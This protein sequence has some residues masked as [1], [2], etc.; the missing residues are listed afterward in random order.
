VAALSYLLFSLQLLF[1]LPASP[2]AATPLK[3]NPL[4]A[5]RLLSLS[6]SCLLGLY[7]AISNT[8]IS[9]LICSA[10]TPMSLS[11]YISTPGIDGG[12]LSPALLAAVAAATLSP[13]ASLSTKT[14]LEALQK[15]STD[16][17]A[18]G[19]SSSTSGGG[20]NVLLR[21]AFVHVR[22][23]HVNPSVVCGE[24]EHRQVYVAAWVGLGA[25]TCGLPLLLL[26]SLYRAGRVP[27]METWVNGFSWIFFMGGGQQQQQLQQQK[28]LT[29]S[30]LFNPIVKALSDL[31]APP[32][33]GW[34]LRPL[35]LLVQASL[36]VTPSLLT[37]R[38][39]PLPI[40]A[41]LTALSAGAPAL[42]AFLLWR[43]QP[44]GELSL[45]NEKSWKGILKIFWLTL[46]AS[47]ALVNFFLYF[48]SRTI[49][50]SAGGA[51][52][53][54]QGLAATTLACGAL[55]F[56]A[57][58][59]LT[60]LA[61]SRK[62]VAEGGAGVGVDQQQQ[63][64]PPDMDPP[65]LLNEPEEDGEIPVEGAGGANEEGGG[66]TSTPPK[67][68]L[69]SFTVN[70]HPSHRIGSSPPPL[71][72]HATAYNQHPGL[73]ELRRRSPAELLPS[74]RS[75]A[76]LSHFQWYS[77][78]ADA[79]R[80]VAQSEMV[81]SPLFRGQNPLAMAATGGLTASPNRGDLYTTG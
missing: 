15:A 50:H 78:K 46:A 16:S 47:L 29:P 52:N 27:P 41:G 23:L 68:Q 2:L 42:Q 72:D 12:A 75:A 57:P 69:I 25:Y 61:L 18:Y 70:V 14:A 6:T 60:T 49:L 74:L 56:L 58:L 17:P 37:S 26:F 38:S 21:T 59:Y 28:K 79:A 64:A 13:S 33:K 36:A 54:Y 45:A 8:L 40:F 73:P 11:D 51:G 66:E 30:P 24:G 77:R 67:K 80:Q 44:Y 55:A 19:S 10:S 34:W 43:C 32:S 76:P 39:T 81:T 1:T 31:D 71:Q 48:F 22:T 5:T 65:P 7:A 9:P 53:V 4:D 3:L 35:D 20:L 63:Q 62:W